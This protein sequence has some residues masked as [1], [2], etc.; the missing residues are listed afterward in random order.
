MISDV[1]N[2][3]SD[4]PGERNQKWDIQPHRSLEGKEVNRTSATVNI[5]SS[6]NS[7]AIDLLEFCYKASNNLHKWSICA[8]CLW[9]RKRG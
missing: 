2:S 6:E 1:Y 9:Q 3:V 7:T 5:S 4:I 8:C